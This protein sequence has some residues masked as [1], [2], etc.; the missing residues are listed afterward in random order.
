MQCFNCHFV[1]DNLN[2]LDVNNYPC[3]NCGETG[4]KTLF[5]N[6]PQL[7]SVYADI[8]QSFFEYD[9]KYHG[10]KNSVIEWIQN[11]IKVD[12]EFANELF[13]QSSKLDMYQFADTFME[14]LKMEKIEVM[15]FFHAIYREK[16]IPKI[17]MSHIV[18]HSMTLL[19]MYL[20]YLLQS[21]LMRS[22]TNL[23]I[24][25]H[26][27]DSCK[28]WNTYF[29]TIKKL[30]KMTWK[31]DISPKLFDGLSTTFDDLKKVRNNLV[32]RSQF[33]DNYQI[34]KDSVTMVSRLL[35]VFAKLHNK[36]L[37]GDIKGGYCNLDSSSKCNSV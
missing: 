27:L 2:M 15:N 34:V 22:Q 28:N 3:P 25:K 9:Q 18:V 5:P 37:L 11:E 16:S 14:T 8:I 10:N 26:T 13:E 6:K 1:E 20:S 17:Q 30:S 24:V 32:H 31:N 21:M 19:E 4:V 36:F 12:E 7:Q 29:K 35:P 23:E 33:V